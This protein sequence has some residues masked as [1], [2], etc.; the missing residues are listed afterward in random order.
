[1][2]EE[3]KQKIMSKRGIFA[4]LF[5]Y[6][7]LK[8][9][10]Y[11]V[12][13]SQT[14]EGWDAWRKKVREE[15]PIQYRIRECIEDM[16]HIFIRRCRQLK[17]SL[18]TLFFPEN[19]LI[20]KA[21]PARG[22][23]VTHLITVM[24]FAAILQFKKEADESHVDWNGTEEHREFKNWLD[25]AVVWIKEGKA[26]LEKKLDEA[27]PDLDLIR[28]VPTLGKEQIKDLYKEVQRLEEL[29]KQTDENIL[30]QMMKYRDYF[31]T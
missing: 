25:L 21:I 2:N 20:R 26:N 15:H 1:M 31:W 23:D 5:R 14:L 24:N 27:Y 9:L 30:V 8:G 4:K 28:S 7:E 29:I 19:E 16:E 13:F 6:L 12:P 22:C 18:R 3:Y 10:M 17:Y 11:T